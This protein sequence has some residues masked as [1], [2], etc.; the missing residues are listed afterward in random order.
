MGRRRARCGGR[1]G[2]GATRTRG[3]FGRRSCDRPSGIDRL[4]P[5]R[6]RRGGAHHHAPVVLHRACRC[7]HRQRR[8]GRGRRRVDCGTGRSRPPARAEHR[9]DG[10]GD[11]AQQKQTED[12]GGQSTRRVR[13]ARNREDQAERKDRRE[14]DDQQPRKA[15]ASP[16]IEQKP[17]EAWALLRFAH[18]SDMSSARDAIVGTPS[19]GSSSACAVTTTAR[20]PIARGPS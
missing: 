18:S 9:D 14:H 15:A 19:R 16:T 17:Q 8:R 10:E 7:E 11:S 3:R 2:R 12:G 6:R 13:A 5:R 1:D 4:R 20:M